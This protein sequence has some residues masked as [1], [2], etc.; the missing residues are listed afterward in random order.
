[1]SERRRLAAIIVLFLI[2]FA[3][4]ALAD[5]VDSVWPLFVT[6]RFTSKGCPRNG[7]GGARLGGAKMGVGR[8][9]RHLAASGEHDRQRNGER[10]S[11][12][13]DAR[14]ISL[15][16]KHSTTTISGKSPKRLSRR[17]FPVS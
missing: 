10:D 12:C 9:D 14:V 15:G 17:A 11:E 1:V 2:G 4:V 13:H 16:A 3:M 7:C 8:L 5:A 6:F